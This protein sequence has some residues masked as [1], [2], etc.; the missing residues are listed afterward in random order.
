MR[1][2]MPGKCDKSATNPTKQHL[3]RQCAPLFC[4]PCPISYSCI[5]GYPRPCYG[6]GAVSN[7]DPIHKGMNQVHTPTPKRVSIDTSGKGVNLPDCTD[8]CNRLKIALVLDALKIE[9]IS[10]TTPCPVCLI[11]LS[12]NCDARRLPGWVNSLLDAPTCEDV[13]LLGMC[14]C[15]YRQMW[16]HCMGFASGC[17]GCLCRCVGNRLSGSSNESI[18]PN[19]KRAQ[20]PLKQ[21]SA[22]VL[23][24]V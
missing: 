1:C 12:Q 20:N 23:Y 5:M 9:C 3:V 15:R 22:L 24:A 4:M 19:I 16:R 6:L 17:V 18:L 11:A 14:L 21:G 13:Q 10:I 8:L 7:T 2:K